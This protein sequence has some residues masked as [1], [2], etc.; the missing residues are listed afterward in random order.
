ML[1]SREIGVD[2]FLALNEI[3]ADIGQAVA[4]RVHARTVF[5]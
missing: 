4:K 1:V 3:A 5:T 2:V